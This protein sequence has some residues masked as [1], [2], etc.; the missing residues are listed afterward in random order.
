MNI[1]FKKL[2]DWFSILS[3]PNEIF[4][5]EEKPEELDTDT[6]IEEEQEDP[7]IEIIEC[8]TFLDLRSFVKE[9]LKEIGKTVWF[10]V[11]DES[12]YYQITKLDKGF[13]ISLEPTGAKAWSTVFIQEESF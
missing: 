1:F 11:L 7:V 13:L 8:K 4:I 9:N 10:S 6:V 12:V 2:K 3:E 5:K